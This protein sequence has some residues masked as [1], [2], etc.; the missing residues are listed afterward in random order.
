MGIS[1]EFKEEC[2]FAI[3]R[4]LLAK[5]LQF[6]TSRL[7]I[8]Q[9]FSPSPR[10]LYGYKMLLTRVL[11]YLLKLWPLV[12]I[13]SVIIIYGTALVKPIETS[14]I[15]L[16]PGE[17]IEVLIKADKNPGTYRLFSLLLDHEDLVMMRTLEITN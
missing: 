8:F 2:R 13:V 15:L 3:F 7:I 16:T 14:E 17:Q 5:N 12:K 10:K 4:L 9:R 6:D 11:A 1:L